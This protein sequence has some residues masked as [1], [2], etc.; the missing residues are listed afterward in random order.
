M[1]VCM[2]MYMYIHTYIIHNIEDDADRQHVYLF[3]KADCR[4][5]VCEALSYYCTWP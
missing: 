1:N 3:A 4:S 2:Y 5:H